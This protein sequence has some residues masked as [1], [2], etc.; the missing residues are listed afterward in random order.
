MKLFQKLKNFVEPC[1]AVLGLGLVRAKDYND[2]KRGHL[3]M[4]R[5]NYNKINI[6][7]KLFLRI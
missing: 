3:L 4:I 6:N 2:G 7:K 5:F 1:D